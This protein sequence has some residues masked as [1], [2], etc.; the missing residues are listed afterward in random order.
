[1]SLAITLEIRVEFKSNI[2]GT[3]LVTLVV[4]HYLLTD[5]DIYHS[6]Y[7]YYHNQ[8]HNNYYRF[9]YRSIDDPILL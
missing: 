9:R 2:N 7:Q 5:C 6:Q 4:D 8:Y 3:C 1:M